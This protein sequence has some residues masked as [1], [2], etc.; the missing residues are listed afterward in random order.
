MCGSSKPFTT[1]TLSKE[2][3][4]RTKLRSRF[5]KNPKNGNKKPFKYK[6]NICITT[7]RRKMEAIFYEP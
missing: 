4:Q 5:L 6:K 2:E 3:M 1:K 7:L